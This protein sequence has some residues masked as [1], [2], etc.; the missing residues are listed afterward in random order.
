M[1]NET[2]LA[3]VGSHTRSLL[4]IS[5]HFALLA[6]IIIPSIPFD[7]RVALLLGAIESV[8]LGKNIYDQMSGLSETS[9]TVSFGQTDSTGGKSTR[10]KRD[11]ESDR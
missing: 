3:G 5:T 10:G 9:L 2:P 8:L 6:V 4:L 1:S 11:Q 7:M